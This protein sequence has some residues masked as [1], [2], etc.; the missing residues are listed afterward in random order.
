MENE[1]NIKSIL[2]YIDDILN[3]YTLYDVIKK[4]KVDYEK[5][6]FTIYT[7]D[8]KEFEFAYKKGDE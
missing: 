3:Q 2:D 5:S 4:V 7:D 8:G 6:S 1:G